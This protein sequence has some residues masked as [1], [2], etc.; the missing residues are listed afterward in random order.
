MTLLQGA[1]PPHVLLAKP[2]AFLCVVALCGISGC[3]YF[4]GLKAPR[5]RSVWCRQ[6]EVWL[7]EQFGR[8]VSVRSEL[9]QVLLRGGPPELRRC[10]KSETS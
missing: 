6:V 10:A 1:N 2:H 7:D 3:G 4:D 8:A 9:C 5:S